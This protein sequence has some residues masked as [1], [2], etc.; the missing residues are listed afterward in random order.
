MYTDYD[1]LLKKTSFQ[2]ARRQVE[3]ATLEKLVQWRG[4]DENGSSELE[5]VFREVIVIDDEDDD[6]P[7]ED[8]EKKS[9]STDRESSVEVVSAS[10]AADHLETRPINMQSAQEDDKDASEEEAHQ[11]ISVVQGPMTR[12][13]D[14]KV[15]RRGFSRYRAWDR[16]MNRYRERISTSRRTEMESLSS[17]QRA[18]MPSQGPRFEADRRVLEPIQDDDYQILPARHIVDPPLERR[19][20]TPN[21]PYYREPPDYRDVDVYHTGASGAITSQQQVSYSTSSRASVPQRPPDILHFPDGSVFEKVPSSSGNPAFHLDRLAE[22]VFARGPSVY[23]RTQDNPRK[24]VHDVVDMPPQDMETSPRSH[25]VLPSIEAP[26][27]SLVMQ[28]RGDEARNFTTMPDEPLKNSPRSSGRRV[29]DLSRGINVID[30]TDDGDAPKRRRLEGQDSVH[31]KR[32]PASPGGHYPYGADNLW[33]PSQR[34]ASYEPRPLHDTVDAVGP[35]AAIH[36]HLPVTVPHHEAVP[37]SP[38]AHLRADMTSVPAQPVYRGTGDRVMWETAERPAVHYFTYAP[39]GQSVVDARYVGQAET[40]YV[41]TWDRNRH[42]D[43]DRPSWRS[44][45]RLY[46][47]ERRLIDAQESRAPDVRVVETWPYQREHKTEAGYYTEDTMTTRT[48]PQAYRVRTHV[49]IPASDAGGDSSRYAPYPSR[50]RDGLPASAVRR[51]KFER[52][53]TLRAQYESL[54]HSCLLGSI[55]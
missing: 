47:N 28:R 51:Y 55:G 26:D 45:A 32:A 11:R 18:Y 31:G 29:D 10:A 13:E 6:E 9:T 4:D 44:K 30:L 41:T 40:R 53:K 12:S 16:A 19:A 8:Q 46:E 15:D 37:V 54:R 1:T 35:N 39:E 22:P 17:N 48:A 38:R 3:E 52:E 27:S 43:L 25:V 50:R 21:G 5:D 7:D 36:D 49:P 34:Y 42:L 23:H 2:E 33:R 24:R 14:P 20:P